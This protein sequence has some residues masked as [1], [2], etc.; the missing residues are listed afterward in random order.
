MYVCAPLVQPPVCAFARN[1]ARPHMVLPH[2][3]VSAFGAHMC[4]CFQT[5][6]LARNTLVRDGVRIS[7]FF[8]LACARK[9]TG[10]PTDVC[11]LASA[12]LRGFRHV[13][14]DANMHASIHKYIGVNARLRV[15]TRASSKC[16]C[17]DANM[18]VV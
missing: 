8:K 2:T 16:F 7:V 9:C 18:C 5:R 12:G 17:T 3:F 11:T 15:G 13:T 4:V 10:F 6:V 1:F 14:V